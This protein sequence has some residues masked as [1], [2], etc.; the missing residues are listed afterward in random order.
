MENEQK[1]SGCQISIHSFRKKLSNR[2]KKVVRDS[3]ERKFSANR[4]CRRFLFR[5]N[6]EWYTIKI[7]WQTVT[8]R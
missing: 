7:T 6:F 8:F 1:I 4:D 5:L 2:E 3:N